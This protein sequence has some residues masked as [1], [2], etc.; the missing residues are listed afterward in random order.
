V[1]IWVSAADKE[2]QRSPFYYQYPVRVY[3][4]DVATWQ[5]EI[6]VQNLIEYDKIGI[7]NRYEETC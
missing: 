7:L 2:L 1:T 4:L 6:P 3:S 5:I